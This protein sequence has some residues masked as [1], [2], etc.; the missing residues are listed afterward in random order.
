M[1]SVTDCRI[2]SDQTFVNDR[3]EMQRFSLWLDYVRFVQ[4]HGRAQLQQLQPLPFSKWVAVVEE[5]KAIPT[6]STTTTI[7]SRRSLHV[8]G[9]PAAVPPIPFHRP[10]PFLFVNQRGFI[11]KHGLNGAIQA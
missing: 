11:E 1:G 2:T 7:P 4:L 9:P 5:K 8:V 10:L 3:V 6:I